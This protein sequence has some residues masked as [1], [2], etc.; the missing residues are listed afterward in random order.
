MYN[1]VGR[2]KPSFK[3]VSSYSEST[4]N[5]QGESGLGSLDYEAAVEA[6]SNSE[7]QS[8]KRKPY[9]KWTSEE[10][11]KIGKY[12]AINGPVATARKFGSNSRPINE[13]TVRVFC[14]MYKAELKA[15]SKEKRSVETK[16]AVLPRGRPLLLGSLDQMVQRFLLAVRSRGGLITSA[17][18]VSVAKALIVRNPHFNLGHIDLDSSHWARSL[19]RRMGFVKRMKTTGKIEIPEGA[20][21][22]AQLLYL[23]DIVSIVEEHN[24]PNTLVMN[25]DQTPLKYIP[26]ANHTLAKKG[27]KSIGIAGSSDKRC[28]TGTFVISLNGDFLPMQLIYGGTTNQSLPRFKF[29]ESFSLSV[30]PKHFSNTFES[31]KIIDEVITPYVEAQRHILGNP[32]QAALLVFDVFRGQIT[33]EVT[34]H[35]A[36]NNIYFVM[37]PNN[38]THLFQPLD[39]TVNGHCKKFMKKK[40]SEWYTQQVDNALQAGVRVEN[41]NI[42]FKL[43]TIKPLH[44]KWI[45][46]YY[47]HVTS[48]AG[49]DVII[50]G[51]KSAG[52]YDAIE[53]GKA[54]LP[55]ID[56]FNEIAPLAVTSNE[57]SSENLAVVSDDLQKSYVNEI[58]ENE[59]DDDC[60]TEWGLDGDFERNAFDFI[61]D[62][63][64]Y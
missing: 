52:I 5:V 59:S 11:F 58:V 13:S 57:I 21:Q 36:Q 42:E 33:D 56:P 45:V 9:Q 18:A 15:A 49:T 28:I 60:D 62:D 6:A 31:I 55:S 16:L 23:H 30:N 53:M 2:K 7:K 19:F 39:L 40:F 22:E 26:S 46:E 1:S 24:I 54:N 44:A 61:I 20:K 35:L 38:M 34:S 14:K 32:N 29:P 25:L 48:E 41:I 27:S 8:K 64:Q 63:E 51:W 47:N 10:R 37:V 12:A 4:W 50:K 3:I 17:I 43:T